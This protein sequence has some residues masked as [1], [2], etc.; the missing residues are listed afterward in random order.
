M[1][2][3]ILEQRGLTAFKLSKE[4]GLPYSTVTDIV[5]GK[6]AIQSVSASVLYKLS[7][8]LDMSMEQLYL[9]D[10]SNRVFYLDNDGSKVCVYAG[11]VMFSFES[12]DNLVGFRNITSVKSNIVYVDAYF[13]NEEGKTFVEE[14]QIDLDDIFEGYEDLLRSEYKV[15]L[16]YPGESRR[17]FIERNSVLISDGFGVMCGEGAPGEVIAD[18]F[19]LK[20]NT[21]KTTVRMIDMAILSSNMKDG[22]KKRAIAVVEKNKDAIESEIKSR[23]HI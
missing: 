4:T 5:T 10:S 18:I 20:R 17:R 14:E 11:E 2:K 16:S 9:G 1:I 15:I 6:T 12:D 7:K 23:L 13:R 3:S 22:M 21:E 19:N 8:A